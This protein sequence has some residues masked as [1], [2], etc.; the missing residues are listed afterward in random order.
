MNH[1]I[2]TGG[3]GFIGSMIKE[4]VLGVSCD[5]KSGQDILNETLL[6][7]CTLTAYRIFHCTALISVPESFEQK[8]ACYRTNSEKII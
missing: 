4:S 7:S 6:D 5:I 3:E 1:F 8:D 2:I